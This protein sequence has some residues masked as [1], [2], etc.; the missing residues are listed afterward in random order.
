MVR[1]TT[2]HIL[3]QRINEIEAVLGEEREDGE[4][5]L[6]EVFFGKHQ[7][8]EVGRAIVD[9]RIAAQGFTPGFAAVLLDLIENL[10]AALIER[11]A[12]RG[13]ELRTSPRTS[14]KVISSE[15]GISRAEMRSRSN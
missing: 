2:L 6:L 5:P 14:W 11:L 15:S 13:V 10:G 4:E 7:I 9:A 12:E 8:A 3:V 1:T